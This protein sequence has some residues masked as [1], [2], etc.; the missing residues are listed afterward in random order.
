[1]SKLIA[2]TG[3]RSLTCGACYKSAVLCEFSEIN[4]EGKTKK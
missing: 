2:V 3:V 4:F 1:M